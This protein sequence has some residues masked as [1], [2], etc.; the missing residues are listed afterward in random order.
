VVPEVRLVGSRC[1]PFPAALR[2]LE[3]GGLD[4]RPLISRM[5]P[6]S[7]G[8]AALDFA[9]APGVLKVLLA[10]GIAGS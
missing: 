10:G 5:F 8:L 2:L 6:L 3:R 1:G 9:R 7:Q 4:P